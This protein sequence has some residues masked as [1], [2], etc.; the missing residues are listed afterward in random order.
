MLTAVTVVAA[1]VVLLVLPG[2]HRSAHHGPDLDWPSR[3]QAAVDVSGLGRIGASGGG[4]PVPIASLAKVMTAYV[5]LRAHPLAG[6]RPGFVLSITRQDVADTARRRDRGES[7]VAVRAGERLT[8]RQALAGLLLPSANNLALA[9][10]ARVS[11]TTAAFVAE[12]NAQAARLGLRATT[13]T[14]PSGYDPGTVSTAADQTRLAEAALRVPALAALMRLRSAVLPVAGPVTNTDTLLGTRGFRGMKTGSD[15]AAG[16][17]FM[18]TAVRTVNGRRVTIT[19]VVLGQRGHR[20]VPAGLE[21]AGRL[22]D[23]TAAWLGAQP[24]RAQ[25]ERSPARR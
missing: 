3:G 17:C 6:G 24:E 1:L 14:D 2:L 21:A 4:R 23:G 19:G 20:L 22:V 12:M 11:G 8:E 10:A 15:R 9:L 16:G 5:V 25:P 18:F 13:Y 7:V